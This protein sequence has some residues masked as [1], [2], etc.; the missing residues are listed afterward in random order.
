[1]LKVFCHERFLSEALALR[2]R[3]EMQKAF[4]RQSMKHVLKTLPGVP[5]PDR[6]RLVQIYVWLCDQIHADPQGSAA[7]AVDFDDLK[8]LGAA[9]ADVARLLSAPAPDPHHPL[10]RCPCNLCSRRR[11]L[12]LWLCASLVRMAARQLGSSAA[13]RSGCAH[14]QGHGCSDCTSEGERAMQVYAPSISGPWALSSAVHKAGWVLHS[15]AWHPDGRSIALGAE[16]RC[17]GGDR[18]SCVCVWVPGGAFA[19]AYSSTPPDAAS[20]PLTLMRIAW[21]PTGAH[22]ACTAGTAVH[23]SDGRNLRQATQLQHA[24]QV[25]HLAWST[26]GAHLAVS[27]RGGDVVLYTPAT[28]LS[29]W[30]CK[31]A[32]SICALALSLDGAR[33]AVAGCGGVRVWDISEAEECIPLL[34]LGRGTAFR[35]AAWSPRGAWLAGGSNNGEVYVWTVSTGAAFWR[36]KAH[37]HRVFS[38]S[39]RPDGERLIS[40]SLSR[41]VRVWDAATGRCITELRGHT[42][43]VASLAW[44]T[45]GRQVV[46]GSYDH[47]V[48]VWDPC[49]GECTAVL[50]GHACRVLSVAWSPG[51]RHA[52]ASAGLDETVRVWSRPAANEPG[53]D[54]D[55]KNS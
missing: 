4:K 37:A 5:G 26:D 7:P 31:E 1:M 6:A 32:N 8:T 38:L 39:W 40:S 28:G 11:H 42:S 54:S 19:T 21:S 18:A 9:E 46:T 3:L 22:L 36:A 51:R 20:V 49:S 14:S 53:L 43:S 10:V 29:R 27:T 25:Q 33:L 48:R 13:A 50:Q 24:H 55:V 23:V 16:R 44:S 47:D 45:D 41:T 34:H 30:L 12:H 15:V 35:A 52:I 17:Q 2:R